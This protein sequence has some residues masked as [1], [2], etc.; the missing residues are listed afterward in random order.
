MKYLVTGG[1]GF[2]GSHLVD[3]LVKEGHFV[4]SLDNFST[5]SSK[6]TAHLRENSNFRSIKGNILDLDFISNKFEDVDR[7]IHLAASVGVLNIVGNPL[8]SLLTNIN[9]TH[10][11]LELCNRYQKPV[12]IASSSEIYGKN[13]EAK[14]HERSNRII[15]SP[16]I[17]R[18]SY[19]D[20]KAID[21]HLALAM[22]HELGLEARI[23]RLFNTVGPRQSDKYGM[24]LPKL[25][26]SALLNEPLIVHGDGRQKRSFGHVLDIVKAIYLIDCSPE[27][28]G[29]PVNI[30][31]ENE[32]SIYELANLIISVT[33]S[34]STIELHSHKDIFGD[35]FEDM[36]RR[37]P[38]TSLLQQ[39]TGWVPERSLLDIIN[40]ISNEIRAR[41]LL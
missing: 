32:I 1:A 22:H 2:I 35:N 4:T 7:V 25:V 12:L 19:S 23:V 41:N 15:G 3:L 11:V 21:E 37:F 17:T 27:T 39:F 13:T 28:I 31:V 34:K 14:L 26:K 20:A 9:G 18:W 40:D 38:D 33:K 8:S 5:G 16:Q 6:N 36:D 29:T 10:N 24:V 30:G